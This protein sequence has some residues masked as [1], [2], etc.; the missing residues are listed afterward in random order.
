MNVKTTLILALLFA[1]GVVSLVLLD[2]QE[3]KQE[4][5]E[6]LA[7]QLL[8]QSTE[9]ATE[10]LIEPSGIHLKR[11]SGEWNL[12][13]PVNTGADPSAVKNLLNQL[14]DAKMERVISSDSSRYGTY[15]LD[16][17]RE[18][19]TVIGP[20]GQ[21]TIYLGD[22]TPTGGNVF[23]RKEGSP[24]VFLSSTSL[25]RE[26]QKSVFELRFK[27]VMEIETTSV[28]GLTVKTR[29]GT[30]ALE[31][32]GADWWL[33]RPLQADADDTKI[34]SMISSLSTTR[35]KSFVTESPQSLSSYGLGRRAR[36][37]IQVELSG[38]DSVQTLEIGDAIETQYYARNLNREPVFRVDSSFVHTFDVT[39]FELR[40][41]SVTSLNQS[42]VNRIE[43][44]TPDH[45]IE[46]WKTPSDQWM[47]TQEGDSLKARNWRVRSMLSAITSASA[48]AFHSGS[49]AR[50]GLDVPRATVQLYRD[51]IKLLKL[52]LGDQTDDHIYAR[53]NQLDTIVSLNKS[54]MEKLTPTPDDLIMT[55]QTASSTEQ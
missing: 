34:R 49:D 51:S 45:H 39:T 11:R 4:E 44:D 33:E 6:Q 21:E 42:E 28:T 9:D 37:E 38:P 24:K 20:A 22:K 50:Y 3:A 41:K 48:E 25:Q 46:L 55:S 19:V 27:N 32:R 23:A 12:I 2:K 53:S 18:T 31:K 54:I 13:E 36:T 15:G 29:G 10:I 1:V 26:A 30:F 52:E 17:Q 47:T 35:A 43:L 7:S 40:E 5:R 16:P 14:D 8:Q